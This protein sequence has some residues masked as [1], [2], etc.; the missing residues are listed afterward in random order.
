MEGIFSDLFNNSRTPTSLDFYN[1]PIG[2][3]EIEKKWYLDFTGNQLPFSVDNALHL[4]CD[5]SS[6]E[7][8]DY[9]SDYFLIRND[10]CN[11]YKLSPTKFADM[12]SEFRSFFY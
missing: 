5:L 9:R 2:D 8:L 6:I 3:Q 1:L 12:Y 7:D 4:I 11:Q 10:L